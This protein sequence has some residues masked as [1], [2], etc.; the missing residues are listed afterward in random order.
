MERLAEDRRPDSGL[1][2]SGPANVRKANVPQASVPE[3]WSASGRGRQARGFAL[4]LLAAVLAAA[5]VFGVTTPRRRAITQKDID[6]AVKYSLDNAPAPPSAASVAY[7]AVEHAVVKVRQLEG[8]GDQANEV[9][10]GT[11]VVISEGGLVI[12]NFHVIAGAPSDA[13]K[14]GQKKAR[15]GLV[16]ADG[17]A[18]DAD[19]VSADPD[20]DIAILQAKAPPDELEPATLRSIVGLKT[21][22]EVFA[23]G[24]PFG[25]GPSLSA[26]VVSGLNRSYFSPIRGNVLSGLIQFDAA[27]NPGNSGGPLIDREGDVVG[28][29]S[30][31]LNPGPERV[32]IGI[33]FAIPFEEATRGFLLNPF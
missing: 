26:G 16:F 23:V 29:V 24:F 33:A 8:E 22:D 6:S 25:I 32:F 30:S 15:L 14:P 18:S 10:V 9:G 2:T 20:R 28:L 5:L 7:Q 27:S 19:V 3:A 4:A 12:T 13:G 1:G 21:G 11:G 17:T 31:I